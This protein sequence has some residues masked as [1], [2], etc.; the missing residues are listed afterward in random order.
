MA[1]SVITLLCD[2]PPFASPR[3]GLNSP[4]RGR[5]SC[6]PRHRDRMQTPTRRPLL[7][8]S[9][10]PESLRPEFLPAKS[11]FCAT[12]PVNLLFVRLY[13]QFLRNLLKTNITMGGGG[14]PHLHHIR[15]NI[16]KLGCPSLWGGWS[17]SSGDWGVLFC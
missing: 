5:G 4:S 2:P 17:Y 9:H 16:G 14:V 12:L 1:T 3:T 8:T 13:T 15:C 10:L 11:L 6:V 7:P